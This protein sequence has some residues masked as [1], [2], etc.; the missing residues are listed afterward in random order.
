MTKDQV[1]TNRE[2][3]LEQKPWLR[4]LNEQWTGKVNEENA[5][6]VFSETLAR[7]AEKYP[8]THINGQDNVWIVKASSTRGAGITMHH[9]Y[10]EIIEKVKERAHTIN[11]KRIVQKYIEN[12]LLI[13][14]RKFD[15]RQWVM[16]TN[17]EP[18][19]VWAYDKTYAKLA[20]MKYD[21][22]SVE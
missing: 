6:L 9:D 17:W 19:T 1:K 3:L 21:P 13:S 12:P 20:S 4:E 22:D 14:S 5:A 18:L 8:Q 10:H 7:L 15:I 16:I 2:Q 11:Q